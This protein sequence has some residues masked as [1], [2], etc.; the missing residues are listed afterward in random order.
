MTRAG[1]VDFR[2]KGANAWVMSAGE[3]AFVSRVSRRTSREKVRGQMPALLTRRSR[4]PNWVATWFEAAEMEAS[5]VISR[6]TRLMEPAGLRFW[7]E[8]RA[9]WPFSRERL[10][11]RT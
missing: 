2:N 10:P 6:G 8:E 11:M 4:W 7:I 3:M 5:D 9:A 1:R